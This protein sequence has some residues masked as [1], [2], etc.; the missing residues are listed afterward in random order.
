MIVAV[1]TPYNKKEQF[2]LAQALER[3]GIAWVI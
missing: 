1:L 2:N 3:A